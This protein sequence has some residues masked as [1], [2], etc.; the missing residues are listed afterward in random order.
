MELKLYQKIF[1]HIKSPVIISYSS[2]ISKCN[3]A[4]LDL[5]RAD[6]LEEVQNYSELKKL[7]KE[8]FDD[9]I[10]T[11]YKRIEDMNGNMQFLEISLST[12]NE[13]D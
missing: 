10:N 2:S 12:L 5:L 4:F 8:I 13:I 6:S 9:G 7:V 1:D 3:R 11:Q